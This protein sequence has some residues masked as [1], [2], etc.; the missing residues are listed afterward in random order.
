LRIPRAILGLLLLGCA[1]PA[2][3]AE[4]PAPEL[5]KRA[6]AEHGAIAS[7]S[8]AA[9]AAG[10]RMLRL[11][12]N[13][14]D[15]A[16]AA[17]FAVGVAEPQMSGIGGGGTA[18]LW[19]QREQRAEY[20]DFYSTQSAEAFRR[21]AAAASGSAP[22][23]GSQDLRV[24][25]IPGSVAGLLALHERYGTLSRELILEPAI[26]L[27]EQG[28]VVSQV[29]AEFIAGDSIELHRDAR[30]ATLFWPGGRPLAAG[31]RLQNPELATA[32]RPIASRGADGFYRGEIAEQVVR[33]LNAGGHPVQAADFAAFPVLWKRP[34]CAEYRGN[35]ILSAPPPQTGMQVIEALQLLEPHAL[36][37][38]GLPT[39]S[40][41]SFDL[42]A[43]ALRTAN[44]D[45]RANDDPRWR[46]VPARGVT[47]A[48]YAAARAALVGQ[49]QARE[50]IEPENAAAFDD[51]APEPACIPLDPYVSEIPADEAATS[52]EDWSPVPAL[53]G[54]S[55]AAL[56]GAD[57]GETTHISV[58]D[59]AGNAVALT[60][61]NSTTFGVGRLVSGFLL[62]DSG[63]RFGT[64][65]RPI[66]GHLPWRTRVS[67]IAPT[68]VL[69]DGRVRVV[70]GAPGAGRIPA[71]VTQVLSYLLDH[72]LEPLEAVRMPRL[73]ALA[74]EPQVELEH[75]FPPETL[76]DVV[77]LGYRPVPARDYARLYLVA[78]YQKRWVAVAEPRHDGGAA[79][80]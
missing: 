76:G 78:R 51:V 57:G 77:A 62:N 22:D 7:A 69:R 30:A 5:G 25:A 33:A 29:L 36:A 3:P 54:G 47:S 4:A 23:T 71:A 66:L 64:P 21:Q 26:Q 8:P 56:T 28:Y 55:V 48:E 6:V 65:G 41:R 68:I 19:L 59:A 34:L 38:I 45:H 15:A 9:S 1:S 80:Y 37:G 10:L 63:Y 13:A 73:F 39:R 67:T 27:A 60:Q 53:A 46:L 40:A 72:G 75:G 58:V 20:V 43:S 52:E 18:L 70:I 14:V 2:P 31:T 61:T 35:V 12:G 42:L 11:G 16:V 79:G 50:R 17:A 49:G 32:L 24:V 44:A 74:A